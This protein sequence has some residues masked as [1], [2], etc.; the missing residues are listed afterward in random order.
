MMHQ[1]WLGL[2]PGASWWIFTGMA[3]TRGAFALPPFQWE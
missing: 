2:D 3:V 1:P